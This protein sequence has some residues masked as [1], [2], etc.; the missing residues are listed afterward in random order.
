MKQNCMIC[1]G[2]TSYF[3]SKSFNAT[4][5]WD[6][7]D[8]DLF[9]CQDCGFVYSATHQSMSQ[10]D[11]EALNARACFEDENDIK[12]NRVNV[13]SLIAN[14]PPYGAIAFALNILSENDILNLNDAVDYAS[15]YGTLAKVL[16]KY[17]KKEIKCY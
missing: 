14:K 9:K 7:L 17:F 15:G 10:I 1:D 13:N 11:W 16:R 5:Y 6:Y 3:F 12:Y 4:K 8:I 2:I